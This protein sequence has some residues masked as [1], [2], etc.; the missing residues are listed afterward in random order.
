MNTCSPTCHTPTQRNLS[1][2][3]AP[4]HPMALSQALPS[5]H[6]GHAAPAQK[7]AIRVCVV[8]TRHALYIQRITTPNHSKIGGARVMHTEAAV[9]CH[10]TAAWQHNSKARVRCKC[11]SKM[12]SIMTAAFTWSGTAAFAATLP[13]W[14]TL[15]EHGDKRLPAGAKGC[16][17]D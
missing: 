15:N 14:D 11:A 17:G 5:A 10:K 13:C 2:G 12:S 16:I 9:C 6:T 7:P 4:S 3:L 8:F 1:K